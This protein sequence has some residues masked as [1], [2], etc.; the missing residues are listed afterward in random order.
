M[1]LIS[2]DLVDDLVI[3][4]YVNGDES[5]EMTYKVQHDATVIEE[6]GTEVRIA[7]RDVQ[8]QSAKLGSRILTNRWTD[9]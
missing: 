5:Q 9:E 2:A 6:N 7:P 8:F 4:G 1:E 3:K